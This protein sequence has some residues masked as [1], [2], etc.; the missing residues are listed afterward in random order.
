MTLSRKTAKNEVLPK[1]WRR[2][3]LGE[4]CSDISYGY[5]A[6]ASSKPIGPKFLRITDIVSDSINWE[7]VPYCEI[8]DGKRDKYTLRIGDIVIARTGATTGYNQIIRSDVPSVFA[9]YLIRCKLKQSIAYPFFIS[10]VLQSA[11]WRNF[12]EGI[13]ARS[14]QPGANAKDFSS[15]RIP[16]PTLPE[17]KAIAS[18]LETWDTA[19]EKTEALIAAKEK[20]FKWLLRT[21]I[22]DEQDNPRWR[23]VRLG[24]ICEKIVGGGTPS[25]ENPDYWQGHIPWITSADIVNYKTIK[26]RKYITDQALDNSATN[27]IPKNNIIVV[28]RVGLGK[29]VRND[30]DVCI[31][32]DS[33]GLILKKSIYP[34]FLINFLIEKIKIFKSASQGSTI[35]GITKRQLADIKI[36]L[37]SLTEQKVIASLLEKAQEEIDILKQLAEQYRTQKRGLMQKLLTGRW[38]LKQKESNQI[39]NTEGTK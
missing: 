19:I 23:E 6:T 8:E 26:Y 18:L 15:F 34:D 4:L 37:P 7:S 12:I 10:C 35:K 11:Y 16:L 20:Q 32:Q 21:F 29:A 36:P 28:T 5:T 25:T 1:G 31:S 30:I 9:S 38:L 3:K 24:E 22:S 14:A 33:Q 2:M 13:K 17:Q 39:S 27:L